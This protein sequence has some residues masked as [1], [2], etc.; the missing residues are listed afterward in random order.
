MIISI[1]GV[2]KNL[3][4]FANSDVQLRDNWEK[5]TTLKIH[6]SNEIPEEIKNIGNSQLPLYNLVEDY[7]TKNRFKPED[8]ADALLPLE[9]VKK[10]LSVLSYKIQ[11]T[12]FLY[13]TSANNPLYRYPIIDLEDGLFQVFEIKQVCML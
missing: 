3:N 8:L 4:S 13:Y 12:D 5:Y 7:G 11:D 6:F 9:K 1:N 10:I 2:R